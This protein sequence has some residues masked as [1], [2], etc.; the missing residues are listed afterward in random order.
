MKHKWIPG[1]SLILVVL[2]TT[3]AEKSHLTA[4][5][6]VDQIS[7]QI[8]ILY[9]NDEHGWMEATENS[10]GAAGMMGLWRENEGYVTDSSFIILS[11]GDMWTGPAISTWFQGESMTEVMNAMEYSAAAIGN[12][13]FDFGVNGLQARLQQADFPFLSANIREKTTGNIPAFSTPYV[14]REVNG[15]RVGIIGLTTTTT[16]VSTFPDNVKDFDFIPYEDALREVV[17][18]VRA[19]GAQLLVV[20][21]H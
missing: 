4:P 8:I 20:A 16:P 9:T 19:A 17:P 11:G 5:N 3:C 21:G 1:L 14:I 15:V 12:H 6:H 7:R 10:G 2:F 18:Q 13:E